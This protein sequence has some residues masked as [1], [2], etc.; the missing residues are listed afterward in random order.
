MGKE[1]GDQPVSEPQLQSALKSRL[2][3][4]R[5]NASS[6][7]LAGIRRLLEEDLG[8]AKNAL[9]VHKTF[10]KQFI[11]KNLHAEEEVDSSKPEKEVAEN[12]NSPVKDKDSGAVN[13]VSE[14]KLEEDSPI[15]G[16][17]STNTENVSSTQAAEITESTIK[18]A[19]QERA[20]YIR[21]QSET[22]TLAGARRYLEGELKLSTN[23]LDPFKKFIRQEIDHVIDTSTGSLDNENVD[24]D[25]EDKSRKKPVRRGEAEKSEREKKRQR[26]E[27]KTDVTSKKP[28]KIVKKQIEKDSDADSDRSGGVSEDDEPRSSAVKPAKRKEAPAPAYGKQVDHLKSVIKACG[29]SVAPTVYKKAKSVPDSKREAF[30]IK[31]LESILLKEGLSKNPSEKE[32]KEVKRRKDRAKELEGIDMSNIITSSRRR[33]TMGFVP[34]PRPKKTEKIGDDAASTK[35]DEDNGKDGGEEEDVVKDA[36]KKEDNDKKEGEK[37]EKDDEEDEEVD[38]DDEEEDEDDEEDDS[39]S[40]EFNDVIKRDG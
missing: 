10:I 7:T 1:D 8:L 40:E 26:T 22:L 38:E 37:K 23:A 21:S 28:R 36:K 16:I 34:P 14:S 9:D 30:L 18:K 2:P 5:D 24:E 31:E 27:K 33:S 19:I 3:H 13:F 32:I 20:E 11:D 4:F 29:M 25:H 15:K 39:Q 12:V 6:L 35:K 17:L